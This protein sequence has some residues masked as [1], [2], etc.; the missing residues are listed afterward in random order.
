[1]ER[2]FE[3]RSSN[4]QDYLY[5]QGQCRHDLGYAI[6]QGM[7][8]QISAARA[9]YQAVL[10][11]N[12]SET[13]RQLIAQG[14]AQY[15]DAIPPEDME[16]I[17][18]IWEGYTAASGENAALHEIALQS[19]AIDLTHQLESRGMGASLTGCTNFACINPDGATAHGQNYDS[20]PKLM[21]ADVFVHQRTPAEPEAFLYRPGGSLGMAVGK[22]EAGV[23]MTVSVVK[24]RC[25]A[26]IMTPRSV[27]VRR[28][29]R[30]ERAI[31]SLRAM[32]DEQG[33]SPFSYNLIVSDSATVAGAQ[34]IPGEQRICQVK[35]TLV[36]SNQFDYVDWVQYLQ[37]PSYSKKRQLYGEQ[38]LDSMLSKYGRVNNQDLLEILADEPVICR[39]KI[40]DGLGTTVLFF[41][42]ES[43]GRGNP[44]DQPAGQLPF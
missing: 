29:L 27:L 22:N 1:M 23:C 12:W 21:G 6:G 44:S 31:D 17:Q 9:L 15:Q 7:H 34:A 33:R 36:Q 14:V 41:T 37:R 10:S 13:A 39:K 42:R 8:R 19:F 32:T 3:W 2:K 16:E 38:L 35:R 24:S 28:A 18:G 4:G 43:F 5:A 26:P 40:K 25:P 11:R 20:D 30:R